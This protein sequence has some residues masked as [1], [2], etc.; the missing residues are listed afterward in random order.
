MTPV[1]LLGAGRLAS[2]GRYPQ[3]PSRE[4]LAR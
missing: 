4:Q 1:S 3:D 2:Y